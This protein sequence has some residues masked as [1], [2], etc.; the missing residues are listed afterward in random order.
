MIEIHVDAV[1][2]W[3]GVR[4]PV[5]PQDGYLAVADW[6]AVIGPLEERP[7]SLAEVTAENGVDS[8]LQ[9][10]CPECSEHV[11]WNDELSLVT[12]A[13]AGE[14]LRGARAKQRA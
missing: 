7:N 10:L 1:C 2:D 4:K 13:P 3:C 12:I 11:A 5:D 14:A 8:E 9:A 6:E